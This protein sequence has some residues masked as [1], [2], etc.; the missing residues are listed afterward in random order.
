MHVCPRA[1]REMSL[2]RYAQPSLP[3]PS[4]NLAGVTSLATIKDTIEVLLHMLHAILI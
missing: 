3:S 2:Y 4:N 1:D